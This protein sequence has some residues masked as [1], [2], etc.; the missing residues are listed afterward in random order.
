MMRQMTTTYLYHS[1]DPP[2]CL[3]W[4]NFEYVNADGETQKTFDGIAY[5]ARISLCFN[6][7]THP[8][9]FVANYA[10]RQIHP[11]PLPKLRLHR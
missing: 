10:H 8:D 4:V 5:L 3:D 1:M 7:N 9:Y 6:K 2:R 11:R